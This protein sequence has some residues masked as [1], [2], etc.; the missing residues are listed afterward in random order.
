[1]KRLKVSIIEDDPLT[2]ESIT[3]HL[4]RMGHEVLRSYSSYQAL[5]TE[6]NRLS[7]DLFLIDIRLR[8]NQTGIDIARRLH[9]EGGPLFLF[10]TSNT[11]SLTVRKA[12]ETLPIGYITKPVSYQDLFIGIELVRAKMSL[13]KK[14]AR[15]I[16]LKKGVKTEWLPLDQIL[17]LEADRSYV[18][19]HLVD[20]IRVLRQSL[21][22]FMGKFQEDE[23]I[24]TH[25]SYAVNPRKV[26]SITLSKVIIGSAKIPLAPGKREHFSKILSTLQE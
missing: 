18:K 20:D 23:M 16:E 13:A 25:R 11:D 12:M 24:R 2:A 3:I 19:L 22:N 17:Y 5:F 6:E 9:V 21:S 7:P 8:G 26:E 10:V 14:G 4:E 1:M 15:S